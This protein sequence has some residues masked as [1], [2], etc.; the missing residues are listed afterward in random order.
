MELSARY[1]ETGLGLAFAT[2]ARGLT[3]RRD[4]A[5]IPLDHYF[6]ADY[7]ALVLRR[8][9]VL[10]PFK[11]AFFILLFGVTILPQLSTQYNVYCSLYPWSLLIAET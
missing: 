6:K 2:L 9:K 3:Q 11:K 7:L 5:F 10:T 8:D 4:L 1:V